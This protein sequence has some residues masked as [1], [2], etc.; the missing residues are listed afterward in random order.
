[1]ECSPFDPK[2][3]S[4]Q[5][6]PPVEHAISVSL[7]TWKDNLNYEDDK[8]R[9]VGA[10]ARGY[11]RF[12]VHER[13]RTVCTYPL[14]LSGDLNGWIYSSGLCACKDLKATRRIRACFSR[15]NELPMIVGSSSNAA[16]P[17][18]G[19]PYTLDWHISVSYL[20]RTSMRSIC[21]SSYSH[22]R[23]SPLPSSSGS[24]QASGY[25]LATAIFV[26]KCSRAKPPITKTRPPFL[27]LRRLGMTLA[28]L[29][30]TVIMI[31]N[32]TAT[33]K[34]SVLCVLESLASLI[35]LTRS[36]PEIQGVAAQAYP[37]KMSS[38]SLREWLQFGTPISSR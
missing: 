36:L 2:I 9:L 26:C 27:P 3:A 14:V 4:G 13:I 35:P 34:R 20:L 19:Q 23:H 22:W 10:L 29:R 12:I 24:T 1:M 32:L 37:A 5:P 15:P 11:P 31:L 33:S 30:Q 21:I 8:K 18:L 6:I 38:F 28:S 7:P 16:L 25:R 17:S